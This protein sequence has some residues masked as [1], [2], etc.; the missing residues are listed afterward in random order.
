MRKFYLTTAIDYVNNLPHIGTA[1]EKIGAD[2]IARF[3]RRQGYKV[4]FQ[5]GSDEHSVNVLKAAQQAGLE[6]KAYCNRMRM[7]FE[8]IWKKLDIS[9]DGFVQTIDPKHARGVQKLFQTLYDNGDIEKR[10]YEGWYC[11]SCEAFYTEKDLEKGLCPNHQSKPKWLKEENYFF[12]LSKYRDRLLQH[13]QKNPSFILP[14][15]RRNEILRVMEG[16][17]Q[18]ISVSRSSVSW[19]IPVPFDPSHVV[20]VWFDALINYITGI[21]FGNRPTTFKKW[22]PADLHII[23]KDIT[24]FHCVIWPAMLMAAG[25]PLPKTVF[26]HGFI[27]LKG[28][29]MSKTLGNVI[30]PMDIADVYG[31]DALRYYLLRTS[32]FGA[33]G[34]FTWDD[35]IRRYN[36]DLANGL[37]NLISRTAMMIEQ[38]LEGK[39]EKVKP[40]NL[41][42]KIKEALDP[43]SGDI[44]FHTAL[45][46]IWEEIAAADK[47]INEKKPW[48]LAKAGKTKELKKVLGEVAAIIRGVAEAL[49]PFLPATAE[50][51]AKQF[52]KTKIQKRENL[53]PRI[54]ERKMETKTD[55]LLDIQDFSKLDLRIAQILAAQKVEGADKL[56][57]LQIDLGGE[58]RQIV[59]GIAQH[60]MPE[61]LIGK[62]IVVVANLKPAKIRGVES[63]GMLLAASGSDTISILTPLKDVPVGSKVK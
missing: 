7:E 53:F 28:E 31:A 44:E 23:G 4:Y 30:T 52:S 55:N 25:L 36:G 61:E 27:Y 17:L 18:D 14:A 42:P 3:K 50:K 43:E 48:E 15:A 2:V 63:H 12:K 54:E 41:L 10:P 45:G 24:R 26:G 58:Q 47:T 39:T 57:Q 56:V 59:A 33:D 29:K 11:E 46:L 51:I 38:Y 37:G 22:W 49:K 20:Y 40:K 13:T 19:G 5:M 21:G 35:F 6:A 60:Y 1:Y 16:G 8:K 62:K 32:S 34:D 9:Y